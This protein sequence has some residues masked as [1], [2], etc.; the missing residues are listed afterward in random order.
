MREPWMMRA[1]D[2]PA[3][4]IGAERMDAP[5]RVLPARLLETLPDVLRERIE[6]R[7][8]RTRTPPPAAPR[9]TTMQAEQRG[10]PPHEARA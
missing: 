9:A 2:V 1:E 5:L 6:G 8:E 4:V 3:E 10:A 7:D